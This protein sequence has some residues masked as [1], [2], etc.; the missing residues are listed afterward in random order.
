MVK[1][2][3]LPTLPIPHQQ[4]DSWQGRTRHPVWQGM[5]L[6]RCWAAMLR[7]T[8]LGCVRWLSRTL[9]WGQAAERRNLGPAEPCLSQPLKRDRGRGRKSKEAAFPFLPAAAPHPARPARCTHS[10]P[11][12]RMDVRP[13]L[14]QYLTEISMIRV[15]ELECTQKCISAFTVMLFLPS[16]PAAEF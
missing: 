5:G 11:S 6:A 12:A 16:G 8:V 3:C 15:S 4:P 13:Y 10:S 1:P 7:D 9:A 2:G 14:T